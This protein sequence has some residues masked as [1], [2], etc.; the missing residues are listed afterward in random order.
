M[1]PTPEPEQRAFSEYVRRARVLRPSSR[2]P[3]GAPV[4]DRTPS[5]RGPGASDESGLNRPKSAP[6]AE[7]R[8]ATDHALHFAGVRL[9]AS[10]PVG[11]ATWTR[12]VIGSMV[13]HAGLVVASVLLPDGTRH[14]GGAARDELFT[15]GAVIPIEALPTMARA[16]PIGRPSP[17]P[18]SDDDALAKAPLDRPKSG[19]PSPTQGAERPP[20][21]QQAEPSRE[22]PGLSLHGL[23]EG[24]RAATTGS[25]VVVDP[26]LLSGSREAY[27]ESA[28]HP[29]IGGGAVQGPQAPSPDVGYE[30]TREKGKLVYH[31]P[32][33]RFVATLRSDGRVDF[34]NKGAK[35]SWSQIGMAGPGDLINAAA[36]ED[37]YARLKAKL[38]SATFDMRL[39][40]AVAFQ[41]KQIDKRLARLGGELDK[42]WTDERRD[43]GTRKELLFQR[44]D[45]CDEPEDVASPTVEL[46]GFG[47]VESSEL[48]EVRQDAA[49]SARRMIE[50]FIRE[51][52]PKGSPEAFTAAELSDMNSRRASKQKFSPYE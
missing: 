6:Q 28:V 10:M 46:P 11:S 15:P 38:L 45:E 42:I 49:S 23:R 50:K 39:G 3:F 18:A 48:D 32:H 24:A 31:D 43:L 27:E 19:S 17:P 36:G 35:A 14:A 20:E 51:H 52:A 21:P 16:E 37:P 1:T 4:R 7:T 12:A 26:S 30:F 25:G 2:P 33:G 8:P 44:W 29:G 13:F 9:S 5:D 40:M 41:K 22:V 34:R 47:T